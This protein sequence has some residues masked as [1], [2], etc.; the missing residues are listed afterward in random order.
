MVRV[1]QPMPA[2][3]TALHSGAMAFAPSRAAMTSLVLVTS[4]C[5]YAPPISF[6]MAVPAISLRSASTHLTPL[7][8]RARAVVAPR[9]DAPPVTTAEVLCSSMLL[10]SFVHQLAEP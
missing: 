4:Q 7:S 6:A 10:L 1:A 9:P 3:L 8:A 5:T 2:Q